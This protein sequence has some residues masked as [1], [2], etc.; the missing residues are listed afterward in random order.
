MR[1][2]QSSCLVPATCHRA[3]QGVPAWSCTK[4]G[5]HLVDLSNLAVNVFDGV[6]KL[7]LLALPAVDVLAQTRCGVLVRA[8]MVQ[9]QLEFL[10]LCHLFCAEFPQCLQCLPAHTATTGEAHNYW[11]L[12]SQTLPPGHTGSSWHVCVPAMGIQHLYTAA[13]NLGSSSSRH[14]SGSDVDALPCDRKIV[15]TVT[16]QLLC[17]HQ[18]IPL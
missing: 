18:N 11:M 5:L 13:T 2:Q 6:S 9:P 15:Q 10:D 17:L 14:I 3:L 16:P 4:P 8:Q 12:P 7:C 1:S